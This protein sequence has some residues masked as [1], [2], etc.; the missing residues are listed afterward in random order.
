MSVAEQSVF[1]CLAQAELHLL[2][3]GREVELYVVSALTAG[4]A[5]HNVDVGDRQ[6]LLLPTVTEA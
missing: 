3:V 5:L 2:H 1:S 4:S 6:S